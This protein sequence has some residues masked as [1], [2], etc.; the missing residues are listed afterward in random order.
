MLKGKI[1]VVTGGGQGIGKHAAKTLAEAGARIVIADINKETAEETAAELGALTE[2]MAVALDVRDEDAVQAAFDAVESK[3]G[4]I[5]ILVNN[6]GIV[7][8]FRW[9]IPRWP[10]ISDMP[11]DFWDRV[12]RT[13]LYGTFFCTKHAIPYMKARSGGHIVNLF[14]GGGPT[15]PGAL[16]YM[17][18]KNGIRT[19]TRFVAEEVREAN[20]CVVTFSPRFAIATETAPESAKESMPR[21]EILGDA[22]VLAAQLPL[23]S[24]GQCV[25]FEDGK[26]V[27]EDPMEG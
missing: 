9:G 26:L 17:V 3:L 7:P 22:F 14:G 20:I 4:G 13:N 1:A 10:Q 16:T 24:S 15:P 23:E 12:I 6:A 18:T 25:A 8:H 11:Q 2:T 21:P 27:P 19:F 5:D